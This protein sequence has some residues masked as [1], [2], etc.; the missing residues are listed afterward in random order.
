M[1][2]NKFVLAG[3]LTLSFILSACSGG[4]DKS[5]STVVPIPQPEPTTKSN[6]EEIDALWSQ[7]V[8]QLV[9]EPLWSERDKYDTAN[10]LMQPM[11]YAFVSKDQA[12]Q[13]EWL[14]FFT[15]LDTYFAEAI[16]DNRVSTT[17][18]MYFVSEYLVLQQQAGN[19]SSV[20]TSLFNK[21]QNWLVSFINSPAWMYGRDPF[22]TLIA[23]T[24]WKLDTQEVDFSYYRAMFDEDLHSLATMANLYYLSQQSEFS[25]STEFLQLAQQGVT[26]LKR[27]LEQEVSFTE[28]GK[29]TWLFQPGVWWQ[30]P[31]Y[32]HVGHAALALDLERSPM[33][34][35][36]TDSSHTH[37]WPLWLKAYNRAFV[38]QTEMTNYITRLQTGLAQ[39]FNQKVYVPAS[40]EVAIPR[41]NNF[42]DVT[43]AFTAI[44]TQRTLARVMALINYPQF[45]TQAGMAI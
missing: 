15:Q 35:I 6:A 45:Y 22:D 7:T 3:V 25:G 11:Q 36:A 17:Q 5:T 33:E 12:K 34:S 38:G 27:M 21:T 37:R 39:Q 23:R 31:N 19:V 32:A 44:T 10:L 8:S 20:T 26:Q 18:F 4:S 43:T 30:H 13:T 28:S 9:T 40:E 24:Q 14:N 41:I 16:G 42:F 1:M 29:D 2:L